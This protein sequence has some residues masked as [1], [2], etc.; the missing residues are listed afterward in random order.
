MESGL[1]RLV[2]SLLLRMAAKI[3]AKNIGQIS[4]YVTNNAKPWDFPKVVGEKPEEAQQAEKRWEQ[5]IAILDTAILSLLGEQEIPD[6]QIEVK[7]DE[8]LSS[9]LWARR[10]ARRAEEQRPLFRQALLGR[11]RYIWANSSVS[12]RR[13]YFLAGMGL[14]AGHELDD[15]AAVG[16]ELLIQANFGVLI[17][18]SD[19]AIEAITKLAELIFEVTPF[20][21]DPFP[22]NWREILKSWLLGKALADSIAG[23]EADGF[24]FIENG[25]VY[26]LPWGMEALRVRGLANGDKIGD[27]FT[28]DEFELGLAVPAVETGTLNRAA[29][30]LVQ[31]GFSSRLAAIKAVTETGAVFTNKHEMLEWLRSDDIIALTNIGIWPTV[32]TAEMWATFCDNFSPTAFKIWAE[33]NYKANVVPF[34]KK[35]TI[36]DGE[37]LRILMHPDDKS[38][39]VI[40]PGYDIVGRLVEPIN[41]TRIGLTIANGMKDGAVHIK[42]F[43]PEDLPV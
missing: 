37:P 43:G 14:E 30:L 29:A 5:W 27:D 3:G 17:N 11:A 35:R 18:D 6:D 23:E 12:Q 13:G 9:S 40:S 8:I 19:A 28:L 31:A 36:K 2:M 16:N 34:N 38:N 1:L 10:L 42:Y 41:P 15:I 33:H 7:L 26:K 22:E 21:P 4:E 32:E 24:G 39:L 20:I 25:L